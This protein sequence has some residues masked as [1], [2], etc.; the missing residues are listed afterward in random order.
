MVSKLREF[1]IRREIG[2]LIREQGWIAGTVA[3]F[4]AAPGRKR[5][6]AALF[7]ALSAGLK[8]LGHEAW[9]RR[10]DDA[11]AVI[12]A[13]EPGVDIL[14][15]AMLALGFKGPVKRAIAKD[16]PEG[17]I[18]LPPPPEGQG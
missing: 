14:A 1:F 10:A 7:F 11:V 18:A 4:N 6:A 15:L 3:W 12:N 2:Q 17:A 16:P 13:I 8:Y 9:A 5:G